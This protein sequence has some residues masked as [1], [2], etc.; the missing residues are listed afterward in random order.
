MLERD[1][2]HRFGLWI[3]LGGG[4]DWSGGIWINAY[5]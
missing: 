1:M 4:M 3:F 5:F 2:I